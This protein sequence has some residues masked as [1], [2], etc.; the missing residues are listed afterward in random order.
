MRWL[1]VA[2]LSLFAAASAV[3]QTGGDNAGNQQDS[4]CVSPLTPR[5]DTYLIQTYPS[6]A[7]AYETITVQFY[8]HTEQILSCKIFD[9]ANREMMVLQPKQTTAPG[10]HTFSIRSNSLSTGTYFVRLVTYTA[11]DA[12]SA[13]DNSRFVIVH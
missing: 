2:V 4:S 3:A 12:Q 1:F 6:P 10:L 11:T 9:V 13:V 5:W 7:K 8:T